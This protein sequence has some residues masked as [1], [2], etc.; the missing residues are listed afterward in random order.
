MFG[1]TRQNLT[2][3]HHITRLVPAGAVILLVLASVACGEILASRTPTPTLAPTPTPVPTRI[4][5]PTPV[6]A[7]GTGDGALDVTLPLGV[8]D[9]TVVDLLTAV[10][11]EYENVAFLDLKLIL[12]SEALRS[13]LDRL[14]VLTVLGP[15]VGEVRDSVDSIL[16]AQGAGG[17]LGVLRGEADPRS[18]AE[19]IRSPDS[20]IKIERHGGSEVLSVQVQVSFFSLVV[21]AAR[22]DET[23]ALF[24]VGSSSAGA[25][26]LVRASLYTAT[27]AAPALS[28]NPSIGRLLFEVPPGFAV[29]LDLRCDLLP[30]LERCTGAVVSATLD[31]EMGS[32]HGVFKFSSPEAAQAAL[33]VIWERAGQIGGS[34]SPADVQASIDGSAVH[35]E[36]AV[37]LE[38]A[39]GWAMGQIGA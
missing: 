35:I 1:L 22:V 24:A 16:I 19:A 8:A 13:S 7:P 15:G 28:A 18:V 34:S 31:G 6:P 20:E 3:L 30:G 32:V 39:L 36:G 23:T 12:G 9:G 38:A 4:P 10:P 27:G 17:I 37:D 33:P 2:Y 11:I 26:D 21:A 25:S 14:G 29:T 5:T